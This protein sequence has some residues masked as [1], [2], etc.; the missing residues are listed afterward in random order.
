M[1]NDATVEPIFIDTGGVEVTTDA[2]LIQAIVVRPTSPGS[3]WSAL[4]RDTVSGR[5]IFKADGINEPFGI[6][7]PA[8]RLGGYPTKNGIYATTITN[9]EVLVYRA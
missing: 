6:S 5:V 3:A 7:F 9:C 1:A 2:V 8:T 4:L